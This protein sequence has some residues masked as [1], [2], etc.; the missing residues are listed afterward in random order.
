MLQVPAG[1]R[2]SIRCWN[3]SDMSSCYQVWKLPLIYWLDIFTVHMAS[4]PA[5]RVQRGEVSGVFV[6]GPRGNM[7]VSVSWVLIQPECLEILYLCV[8]WMWRHGRLC[9]DS[10]LKLERNE[11]ASPL[12]EVPVAKSNII[13]VFPKCQDTEAVSQFRGWVLQGLHFSH[14]YVITSQ[15]KT[16][17]FSSLLGIWRF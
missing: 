4:T 12:S 14:R 10:L 3:I 11:T 9:W 7:S 6:P 13:G 8:T 17:W 5:V 1:H 2:C 15:Q 16:V